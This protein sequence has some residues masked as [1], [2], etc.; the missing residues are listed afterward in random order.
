MV[1]SEQGFKLRIDNRIGGNSRYYY[2]A[3]ERLMLVPDEVRKCVAFLV[4]RAQNGFSSAGTVFFV[5]VDHPELEE[6]KS[7]PFAVTAKHVIEAITKHSIDEKAYLRLNFRDGPARLVATNLADWHFHPSDPSVDVAVLPMGVPDTLVDHLVYPASSFVTQKVI[8]E[9]MI[10]VGEEIF[11][12]GLFTEHTGRQ[13]NIPI[14]RVGNIAAMPEEPADAYLV[15]AR[16]IGGLSGSPVFVH[17]GIVRPK[18]K[19]GLP[20]LVTSPT[21]IHYLLGLMHGHWFTR[22]TELDSIA[23]DGTT[24]EKINMGIAIVIPATKILEVIKQPILLEYVA[25]RGEEARKA[26]LPQPD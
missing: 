13:R 26:K 15:E 4:C 19:E 6:G 25:K 7:F 24:Q 3:A 22:E 2:A 8:E 10:G 21:G 11:M 23:F 20:R 5:G 12:V 18:G 9:E 16:S 14:I 1:S 17:L